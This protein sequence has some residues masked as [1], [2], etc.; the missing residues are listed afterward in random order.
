[1]VL[2][3]NVDLTNDEAITLQESRRGQGHQLELRNSKFAALAQ[4]RLRG[5]SGT[6]IAKEKIKS[7]LPMP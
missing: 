7:D 2:L 4:I 1:M 5:C 3:T 6:L